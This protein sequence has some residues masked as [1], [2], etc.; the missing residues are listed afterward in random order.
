MVYLYC[1]SCLRYTILVRNPQHQG[2]WWLPIVLQ[3]TLSVSCFTLTFLWNVFLPWV[4]SL[5]HFCGL[6]SPVS[7]F[8]LT[9]L[10]NSF[11]RELL[12]WNSFSCE[13]ILSHIS[14][15][16][17]SPVTWFSLRFLWNIFSCELIHS[18]ISVDYVLPWVDSLSHFWGIV[19]LLWVA[20]L[21]YFW[22]IVSPVNCFTLTFLWNMF[23]SELL[24]SHISVEYVL[25]WVAS[26]SHFWGIVSP[27]SW[28]SLT[29]LG[30]ILSVPD[31]TGVSLLYSMLEIHHSGREPSTPRPLLTPLSAPTNLVRELS[32]TLTFLGN[33]FSYELILSHI[34]GQ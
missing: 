15:E 1:I 8:T 32:F 17:V 28:F 22:A 34:S 21:S 18:H 26:P 16:D 2:A 27:M 6:C 25:L 19:S 33:M 13:L 9:F 3:P 11:S 10:W 4:A 20:S 23:S 14:V 7:W 5:S 24:H 30:N 29:C 12:V 31:Q